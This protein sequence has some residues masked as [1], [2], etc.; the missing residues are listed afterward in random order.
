M[1][2]RRLAGDQVEAWLVSLHAA[3]TDASPGEER[4]LL[5]DREREIAERFVSSDDRLRYIRA[6]AALRRILGSY[7]AVQPSQVVIGRGALG[8]P[9]LDPSHR[10]D[11]RFNLSH[12]ASLAIVVV[13]CG[14]DIGVDVEARSRVAWDEWLVERSLGLAVLTRLRELPH[15]E[16]PGAFLRLWTRGEAVLKARGCGLQV[17]FDDS[18]LEPQDLTVVE[19]APDEDHVAAIA[20]QGPWRLTVCREEQVG[21]SRH[22]T[23]AGDDG[24][25][26]ADGGFINEIATPSERVGGDISR[27]SS[28]RHN[29]T[30]AR[31]PA[32]YRF[33]PQT[34]R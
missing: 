23:G 17:P 12:A 2:Q 32:A 1:P 9:Y 26:A 4:S 14:A 29:L 31:S 21:R 24:R 5:D 10:S 16:R 20:R 7:L 18:V 13:T 33:R 22:V 27:V 28:P 25:M 30:D 11:L 15:A 8:K 3:D 34:P 6:H 19:F